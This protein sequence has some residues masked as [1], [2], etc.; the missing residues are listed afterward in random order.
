MFVYPASKNRGWRSRA[1]RS[2]CAPIDFFAGFQSARVDQLVV[3]AIFC[4]RH[5]WLR[6]RKSSQ[7]IIFLIHS[8]MYMI[9]LSIEPSIYIDLFLFLS[10]SR[11]KICPLSIWTGGIKNKTEKIIRHQDG[12]IIHRID[13]QKTEWTAE[14]KPEKGWIKDRI[15]KG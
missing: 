11:C 1:C 7:L 4:V 2:G 14:Q 5:Y 6:F 3:G 9:Y 10:L 8:Y 13:A 15:S 12:L